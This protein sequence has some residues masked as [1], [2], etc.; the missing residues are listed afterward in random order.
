MFEKILEI[1]EFD[2]IGFTGL[3]NELISFCVSNIFKKSKRD[4]L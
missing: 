4:I 3:T 1:N 2:N